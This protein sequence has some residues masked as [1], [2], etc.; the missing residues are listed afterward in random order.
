M[1]FE[2]GKFSVKSFD[3]LTKSTSC[4][5]DFDY[6]VVATGHFSYPYMPDFPGL[7]TFPGT[8]C[9]AHD[10]RNASA[11]KNMHV[12]VIG[13]SFSAEDIALQLLKFG[14]KKITITYRNNAMGF[15]WPEEIEVTNVSYCMF[16]IVHINGLLFHKLYKKFSNMEV[17][18]PQKYV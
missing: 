15:K 18:Y 14:A 8:I 4:S 6:L 1:K 16:P 7:D 13:S 9:H 11:F 5:G 3:N 2:N 10:F 12:L 17:W